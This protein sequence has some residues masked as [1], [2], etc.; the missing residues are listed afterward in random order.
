MHHHPHTL[1][2]THTLKNNKQ[3]EALDT[4]SG[5]LTPFLEATPREVDAALPPLERAKAHV[6]LA[7]AVLLLATLRLRLRGERVGEGH[8]L[9]QDAER[10]RRYGNKVRRALLADDDARRGVGSG[11]GAARPGGGGSDLNVAAANR[12][13]AHAIPDLTDEQK[14]LLREQRRQG[15]GGGSAQQQQRRQGREEE[16]GGG[17][18]GG[19][20]AA[21]KR[22]RAGEGEGGDALGEILAAAAGEE[23]AGGGGGGG[24]A[25]DK[26][27]SDDD[28]V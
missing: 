8:V 7:R 12:F 17:G 10:L 21:N 11:F 14:R 26:Q 18:G 25:D 5:F 6:T 19:G 28:W 22:R 2:D 20:G 27:P 1:C 9:S 4:L 23:P 24:G 16:G 3:Q 13:I 15:P